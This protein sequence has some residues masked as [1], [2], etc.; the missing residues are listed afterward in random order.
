[1][2]KTPFKRGFKSW[3]EKK[4]ED[5]RGELGL[6]KFAP[7]D[8]FI[9]SKHL[10]IKALSV[11]EIP[12]ITPDIVD[13]LTQ[14]HASEFSALAMLTEEGGKLIIF[15]PA[16]SVERTQSNV[17]HELAHI[18]CGHS[19]DSELQANL[20]IHLREFDEQK[21]SEA[22]WLSGCLLFPKCAVFSSLKY[23]KEKEETCN[24]YKISPEMYKYRVNVTGA[25][26]IYKR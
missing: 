2:S 6:S 9:L 1:M 17:M 18:I 5:L 24:K 22:I 4:A 7:L 20:P 26:R 8:C 15:N 25:L 11:S 13:V 19:F 10:R 23:K 3:A 14:E 16:H 12:G 21:E